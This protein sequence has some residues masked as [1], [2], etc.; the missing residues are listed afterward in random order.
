MVVRM[1][2]NRSQ[3]GSRRSDKGFKSK[4]LILCPECG[5]YKS[6]H[7]VCDNCGMYKG[8]MVIDVNAEVARKQRR[9]QAK[10]VAR[11][12]ETSDEKKTVEE[13]K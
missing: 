6:P 2:I 1:R 10:K 13:K 11:G 9:E 7:R 5:S 4:S 12:E 8:R 3:T